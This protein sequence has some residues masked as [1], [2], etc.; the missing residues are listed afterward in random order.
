MSSLCLLDG[1]K[2]AQG[3]FRLY[4]YDTLSNSFQSVPHRGELQEGYVVGTKMERET[5]EGLEAAL[6]C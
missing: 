5:V 2:L 1:W 6:R 4:F 3:C